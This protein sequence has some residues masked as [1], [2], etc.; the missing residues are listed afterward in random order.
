LLANGALG[1]R[2]G[3]D[4][5]QK[6]PDR[7]GLVLLIPAQKLKQEIDAPH[8]RLGR[9]TRRQFELAMQKCRQLVV[10]CERLV[11]LID[12]L[13][14]RYLQTP[15]G[16]F[17]CQ[18]EAVEPVEDVVFGVGQ[19]AA[20]RLVDEVVLH[21]GPA[22]HEDAR[23]LDLD[24]RIRVAVLGAAQLVRLKADEIVCCMVAVELFA[25]FGGRPSGS[26]F[27]LAH[28]PE[29]CPDDPVHLLG[30]AW[31]ITRNADP[32]KIDDVGIYILCRFVFLLFLLLS[33]E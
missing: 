9:I 17:T 33:A 8:I 18:H 22:M 3:Y 27:G 31:K 16:D 24:S 23:H 25:R 14:E 28:G 13:V 21:L 4:P 7:A 5:G 1:F 12:A 11:G 20:Q 6:R 29:G 2:I 19:I 15:E 32:G 10:I 26:R 30:V